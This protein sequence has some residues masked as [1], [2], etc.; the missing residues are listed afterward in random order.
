MI[1]LPPKFKQALGNGV[2]TSL[3]PLVRIYKGIRIDDPLENATEVINLSIKETN[4]GGSAYKPLLLNTPSIKSSADIINNKYT[5][6]SVSLSISNAP[7]QGKIF[8]DDIQSLL[9]AV[10]QV[11]YC[12]NGIDSIDDCLLVYT[13]TI[14]RLNQSA[15]NIK[16]E[17]E[18]LTQQM[19]STKIPSTL[20]PD[21]PYYNKDDIGKPYPMVYGFVDKSPLISRGNAY[22]TSTIDTQNLESFQID[23]PNSN[24]VGVWNNPETYYP[25]YDTNFLI[26]SHPLYTEQWLNSGDYLFLGEDGN[27]ITINRKVVKQFYGEEYSVPYGE[28]LHYFSIDELGNSLILLNNQINYGSD[29]IGTRIFRPIEKV[30]CFVLNEN[31]ANPDSLNNIYGFTGWRSDADEATPWEPWSQ[32][33]LLTNVPYILNWGSGDT[34]F[35]QPSICNGNNFQ[36][37][38]F[39]YTD[40]NWIVEGRNGGFPVE[41]LQNGFIDDGIY[42]GGRNSD[43]LHG[44]EYQSGGCFIKMDLFKNVPS[45]PCS[46]FLLY[47]AEYHSTNGMDGSNYPNKASFWTN[48]ELI[49]SDENFNN[50]HNDAVDLLGGEDKFPFVP[51]NEH[52]FQEISYPEHD[53]NEPTEKSVRTVGLQKGK[54]TSFQDTNSFASYQ[55]G[56]PQIPL[57]GETVGNDNHYCSVQLYNSFLLQDVKIDKPFDRKFYA[58]IAGRGF[59]SSLYASQSFYANSLSVYMFT[60]LVDNVVVF[61]SKIYEYSFNAENAQAL[62]EFYNN[63]FDE[64]IFSLHFII[65]GESYSFPE[66]QISDNGYKLIIYTELEEDDGFAIGNYPVDQEIQFLSNGSYIENQALNPSNIIADIFKKELNYNGDLNVLDNNEFY[67]FTL[68]EQQEVKTLIEGI[69]K[70]SRTITSYDSNGNIK[71]LEL[72]NIIEDLNDYPSIKK[73]DILKYSFSLTKIDDIVNQVNVKYSKNYSNNEYDKET[74]YTIEDNNG[75][76]YDNLDTLTSDVNEPLY[77]GYNIDYYGLTSE[78]AKL[79]VET[80]YIRDETQAKILQ[81]NILLHYCNQHLIAKIEL[82]ASYMNLEAGDYI[83]FDEL[84]GSKLA[85][86][87]DYTKNNVKNGQLIYGLFFITKITK[88]LDKIQLELIQ[89]HRKEFGIPTNQQMDDGSILSNFDYPNPNENSSYSQDNIIDESDLMGGEDQ[90]L[91]D[92]FYVDWQSNQETPQ[93]NNTIQ[94]GFLNA[95]IY[96]N[97]QQEYNINISVEY[98]ESEMKYIHQ[99]AEHTIPQGSHSE[100]EIDASLFFNISKLIY[101]VSDNYSGCIQ[102]QQLFNFYYTEE[103]TGITYIRFRI[104]ITHESGTRQ[105]LFIQSAEPEDAMPLIGDVNNDLILNIQDIVIVIEMALNGEYNDLADLNGDGEVNIL[106]VV[107]LIQ[108]ILS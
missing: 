10:V 88:S 95:S 64:Q 12:S 74:G 46:S 51:N 27:F 16:L 11:Y 6:S 61:S 1:E 37:G 85:F 22:N 50:N 104:N 84:I 14:R 59:E 102:V 30:E 68:N 70:H 63:V 48:R 36:D 78:E 38:I 65:D 58:S 47:E 67:S 53:S 81:K 92:F 90:V 4:I 7:F 17:L 5:I 103:T 34:S 105:I 57:R 29:S 76:I 31:N 21:E 9:N 56:I 18:D 91:T 97:Q 93:I 32:N 26:E 20:I 108:M 43:G 40:E 75:T 107:N 100:G 28:I 62:N 2:R 98:A 55:F 72:K 79:E 42:L 73:E 71:F 80:D 8:S 89:L 87:L 96:T 77:E 19:L 54:S 60:D 94:N 99:G 49:P 24:I 25:S 33:S 13:G 35:W 106:D 44:A 41:R 101:N 82:P 23:A 39:S 15:E 69:T 86:G 45:L 3:Y 52:E 83:R 66:Y